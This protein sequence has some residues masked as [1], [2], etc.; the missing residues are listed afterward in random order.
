VPEELVLEQ[1]LRLRRAVEGD[2]PLGA[3][4]LFLW[5]AWA[6]S[7][8]PVPDS[9]VMSTGRLLTATVL[10]VRRIRRMG[11]DPAMIPAKPSCWTRSVSPS[12]LAS[13][14]STAVSAARFTRLR[15]TSRSSGFSMKSYAPCLN[16]ARAVGTSP[17]AVTM[18]VSACGWSVRAESSTRRP[19]SAPSGATPSFPPDDGIRKSVITM[20][21]DPC[22][23]L[24]QRRPHGVHDRADVPGLAQRIGHHLGVIRL[25]ID[26]Q[27]LRRRGG[28]RAEV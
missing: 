24:F 21:N 13:C 18:I 20:S 27:H 5:I 12:A 6:M 26:D 1:V 15:N 25:V 22:P 8:L 17:C 10:T 14:R 16:A 23:K 9:P 7:S 11:S 2:E 3:R 28:H 4:G 19:A